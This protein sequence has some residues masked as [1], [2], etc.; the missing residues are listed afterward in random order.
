MPH[1]GV[2]EKTN[3]TAATRMNQT[4]NL[5]VHATTMHLG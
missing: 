3:Q 4:I 1:A 5:E 2:E